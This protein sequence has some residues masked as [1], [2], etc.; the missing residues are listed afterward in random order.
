MSPPVGCMRASP[1][2]WSSPPHSV[3][4]TYW[5][6]RVRALI[7]RRPPC[8]RISSATA[9]G[10]GRAAPGTFISSGEDV[11]WR[12]AD[13]AVTLRSGLP[14]LVCSVLGFVLH[15]RHL[16]APDSS[17]TYTIVGSRR[18]GGGD[19]AGARRGVKVGYSTVLPFDQCGFVHPE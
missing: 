13:G 2:P 1:A 14:P 19:R 17:G 8:R 12:L 9:R 4:I 6:F 11:Q 15:S 16:P 18:G 7:S 3:L 10:R 5:W